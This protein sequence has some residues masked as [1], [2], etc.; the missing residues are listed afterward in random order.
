M[1][2]RKDGCSLN[3]L[4]QICLDQCPLTVVREWAPTTGL[5][6]ASQNEQRPATTVTNNHHEDASTI[7]DTAAVW[8]GGLLQK[9][10]TKC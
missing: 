7:T 4:L 8:R 6:A 5:T 2:K 1:G 9:E 10:G 3:E